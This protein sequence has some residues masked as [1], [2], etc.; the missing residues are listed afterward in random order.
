M[1]VGL[2]SP[3][4]TTGTRPGATFFFLTTFSPSRSTNPKTR[5]T[6][7]VVSHTAATCYELRSSLFQ[8]LRRKYRAGPTCGAQYVRQSYR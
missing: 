1:L 5:P 8:P 6:R 4:R 3:S 7:P 2:S